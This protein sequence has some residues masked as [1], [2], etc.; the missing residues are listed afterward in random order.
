MPGAMNKANARQHSH[1]AK[2]YEEQKL[3]TARNKQ[4]N[5]KKNSKKSQDKG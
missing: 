3:R 2:K 4:K 1:N 5:I